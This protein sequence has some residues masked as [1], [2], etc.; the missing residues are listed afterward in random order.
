ME[1]LNRV[2]GVHRG[3]VYGLGLECNVDRRN[4]RFSG[5]SSSSLVNHDEFTLLHKKLV[6]INEL[7]LTENDAREE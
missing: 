7:Y 1:R 2:G 6:K 5:A 4:S 3:R